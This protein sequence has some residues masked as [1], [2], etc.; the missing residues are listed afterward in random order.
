MGAVAG[1]LT[2][3]NWDLALASAGAM[4]AVMA[5]AVALR[6][7]LA[8][9]STEVV[10][11]LERTVGKA[12]ESVERAAARVRSGLSKVLQPL[13]WVVRPTKAVELS[14]LR[15]RLI[16]AGYRGPHALETFLAG[17]VILAFACTM[18][19]LQLNSHLPRHL[20]FP[21]DMVVT[22]W[23]CIIAFFAPNFWLG[24]RVRER[25]AHIERALPDAMDLLVTCVEAGLGI[26]AAMAR[27]ADEIGLASPLL[28]SEMNLTGL[29]VQAGVPRPDAFRRLAERTGVDDLR[30]LSAMLIQTELF[31]TSVARALRVHGDGMRVR[32]MQRAEERAAMVGVKMTIPLVLFILPS[33]ISVLVGPAMVSLFETLISRPGAR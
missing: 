25:K 4:V 1:W 3:G 20:E 31:G 27:V 28:G 8:S 24:S 18:G 14:R 23:T 22:V 13:S 33:L 19:F 30:S 21:F 7:M 17:K 5:A 11:R 2:G 15:S 9:R 12:P 32:R 10:D 6:R 26:D 29:E 16:Q